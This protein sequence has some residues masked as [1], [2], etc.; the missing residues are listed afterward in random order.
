MNCTNSSIYTYTSIMPKKFICQIGRDYIKEI[1]LDMLLSIFEFLEDHGT[2]K[3]VKAEIEFLF[4]VFGCWCLGIRCSFELGFKTKA[5]LLQEFA[6]FF[7][8]GIG[9]LIGIDEG[10]RAFSRFAKML[11]IASSLP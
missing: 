10:C 3:V 2:D 7:R 6:L 5:V 9:E 1:W 4:A 8:G 11:Q